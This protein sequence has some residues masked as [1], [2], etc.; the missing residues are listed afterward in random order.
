[1]G[2]QWTKPKS[3]V[4]FNMGYSIVAWQRLYEE[5]KK[6]AVISNDFKTYLTGCVLEAYSEGVEDGKKEAK[7]ETPDQRLKRRGFSK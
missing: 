5:L 2:G 6:T 1:V 4:K 3:G 7:G